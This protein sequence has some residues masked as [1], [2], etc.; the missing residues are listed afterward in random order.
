MTENGR[1]EEAR[2]RD[3]ENDK[4]ESSME[5]V[6]CFLLAEFAVSRIVL[7]SFRGAMAIFAT[8]FL[9]HGFNWMEG[10]SADSL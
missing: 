1:R 8:P 9:A 7:L 3:A 2:G 6:H 5:V 4:A 10:I